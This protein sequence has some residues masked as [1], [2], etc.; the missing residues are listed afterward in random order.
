MGNA[1]SPEQC[2]Q[3]QQIDTGQM[4]N[5][6]NVK[7]RANE[8]S[9]FEPMESTLLNKNSPILKATNSSTSI[10]KLESSVKKKSTNHKETNDRDK[11]KNNKSAKKSRLK[12]K[13]S[14]NNFMNTNPQKCSNGN[15][16]QN[17]HLIKNDV[18]LIVRKKLITT[19]TTLQPLN[20]MIAKTD[21][22]L[23]IAREASISNE[24]PSIF[25]K[26]E[27]FETNS[28][29]ESKLPTQ[30]VFKTKDEN[31]VDEEKNNSDNFRCS[32][33]ENQ[34]KNEIDNRDK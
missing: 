17:K 16:Q 1:E 24:Y 11:N 10:N 8:N 7:E 25:S 27:S 9:F 29:N 2:N 34:S 4:A 33:K 26:R 28:L 32:T 22:V 21:D 20:E 23:K 14:Y 3:R 13:K 6:V 31:G 5:N 18:E 19:T 15:Q 12:M 30:A